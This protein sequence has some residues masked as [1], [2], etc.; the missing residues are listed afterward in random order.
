M[1][2]R[3]LIPALLWMALLPAAASAQP[4][5]GRVLVGVNVAA[6]TT[7][8]TFTDAFTYEHVYS[9][10]IPGEEASVSSSDK[11]PAAALFDGG[12]MVR[13]FHNLAA[14]IAYDQSS[15]TSDLNLTAR[16]PHPFQIAQHRAVEGTIPARHEERGLHV[17]A[18]YVLPATRRLYVALAAGPTYF[19]VKQKVVKAV[20]VSETYPYDVASFAS[21]DL[22][23]LSQSG[24]GFNAGA[25]VGWMFNRNFGAGGLLRYSTATLS[26]QP[27]GRD[28]R[29]I[30]VGGLHVGVGARIAF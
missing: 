8:S 27:S 19:T 22:E 5:Q 1:L 10:N 23:A 16:I 26:L 13:I 2:R 14:G 6:P 12:V 30:E 4:W 18:A 29:D 21:A 24:W 11:T 7:R 3:T 25:D 28:A 20:T 17:N 9:V 15:S